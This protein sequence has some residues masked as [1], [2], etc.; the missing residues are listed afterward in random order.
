MLF[1]NKSAT[2]VTVPAS[3]TDA[4]TICLGGGFRL[5]AVTTDAGKIRLGGGFR[6]PV[7][8]V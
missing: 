4:G 1:C 8:A 3:T 2:D 6:L 5:P 7:C